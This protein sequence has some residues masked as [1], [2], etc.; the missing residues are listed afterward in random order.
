MVFKSHAIT[1]CTEYLPNVEQSATR[2]LKNICI[3]YLSTIDDAAILSDILARVQTA[4]NMTDQ[5]SALSS[6]SWRA[7]NERDIALQYFYNQWK[8][9]GLVM[10]KWLNLQGLSDIPGNVERIKILMQDPVFDIKNPNKVWL[11]PIQILCGLDVFH[12]NQ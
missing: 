5:M 11:R 8:H 1:I 7:C 2:A 12:C 9:D 6:L 4:S 10:V 3:R